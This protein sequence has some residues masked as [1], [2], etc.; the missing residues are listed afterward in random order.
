MIPGERSVGG[1]LA[2]RTTILFPEDMGSLLFCMDF[3][4]I[5][6]RSK[7]STSYVRYIGSTFRF[8]HPNRKLC[9]VP[10]KLGGGDYSFPPPGVN[11]IIVRQ[12]L[13]FIER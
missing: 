4:A 1:F 9:Q 10:K 6:L 11:G 3:A 5:H 13:G 8:R 7:I 12:F 2:A